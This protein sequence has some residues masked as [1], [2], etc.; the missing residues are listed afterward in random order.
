VSSIDDVQPVGDA[1][2]PS[3]EHAHSLFRTP[4]P[5]NVAPSMTQRRREGPR[6]MLVSA[7]IEMLFSEEED[8]SKRIDRVARLGVNGIEF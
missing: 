7:C 6:T 4:A 5:A 2:S 3:P 8:V 1:A